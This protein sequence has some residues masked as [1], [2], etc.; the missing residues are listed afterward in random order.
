MKDLAV[1]R[2]LLLLE[3]SGSNDNYCVF[4]DEINT[5]F[6]IIVII[7]ISGLRILGV[8][9]KVSKEGTAKMHLDEAIKALQAGDITDA[10]TH[11]Q[12]VQDSL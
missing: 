5:T 12:M 7:A 9:N 10:E 6:P 4:I 1:L 2:L 11:T 3:A 8:G